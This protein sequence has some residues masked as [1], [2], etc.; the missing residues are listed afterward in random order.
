MKYK[1]ILNYFLWIPFAISIGGFA[2]Y[3]RYLIDVKFISTVAVTGV[4]K[5]AMDRYLKIGLFSLFA[6][7]FLLFFNKLSKLIFNEDKYYNETY[8][9]TNVDN[10]EVKE[11]DKLSTLNLKE[12]QSHIKVEEPLIEKTQTINEIKVEEKIIDTPKIVEEIKVDEPLVEKLKNEPEFIKEKDYIINLKSD[13]EEKIVKDIKSD[14]ILKA[15]FIDRD[16]EKLIEILTDDEEELE[17]LS[18]DKVVL[19]PE[20]KKETVIKVH[21]SNVH[22]DGYKHCPKCKNLVDE[23]AVICV[24]CGILLNDKF[25]KKMEKKHPFN[26]ISFAINALII[27]FGIIG[28]IVMCNKIQDQKAV[29]ES[30]VGVKTNINNIF[31]K[32]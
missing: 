30:K 23:D 3:F 27:I 19:M 14:K 26:P 11:T 22:V 21:S 1:R 15:R 12:I 2:L 17:V 16:D 7:F 4:I 29:N 8:P 28:I 32:N 6:G 25:K 24:Y 18:I 31:K 5:A 20:V 10:Y 13:S 9:W